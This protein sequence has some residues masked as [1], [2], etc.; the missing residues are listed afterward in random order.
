MLI[1][2]GTSQCHRWR[3]FENSQ[4]CAR[5]ENLLFKW[6]SINFLK[7]AI[8]RHFEVMKIESF[9]PEKKEKENLKSA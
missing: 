1:S 8:P 3:D 6:F 4:K 9:S 7:F 5:D 2:I